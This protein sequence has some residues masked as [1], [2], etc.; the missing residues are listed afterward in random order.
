MVDRDIMWGKKTGVISNELS[1]NGKFP[2]YV[3]AKTTFWE[4]FRT[5]PQKRRR[6]IYSQVI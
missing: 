3:L 2:A 4:N 5:P 1:A 6:N